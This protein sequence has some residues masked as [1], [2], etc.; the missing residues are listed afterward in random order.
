MQDI[1]WYSFPQKILC[2]GI[3]WRFYPLKDRLFRE[4]FH[5]LLS[6]FEN[7]YPAS[8][9]KALFLRGKIP[10]AIPC[11]LQMAL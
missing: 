8:H 11:P 9:S 10:Q 5:G 3:P 2:G 4:S 6:H 7:V 1:P